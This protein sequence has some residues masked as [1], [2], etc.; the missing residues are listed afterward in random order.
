MSRPV[1]TLL[2]STLYPSAARPLHGIFVET[3]L[4]ELLKTGAVDSRVVAPVPWFPS[5]HERH[6]ERARMARTPSAESRHGI[7]VS[8]PRYLLLPKVGMTLAPWALARAGVAAARRLLAEGFDFDVIDAH[9]FYPDGVAAAMMARQ[10]RKPLV[11]TARGSDIN[12]IGTLAIPRRLMLRAAQSAD[13]CVGVSRALVESMQHMGMA[14][15]K[16][17]VMRNGIDLK[18]FITHPQAAAQDAIGHH[19]QPLL[20]SVGN[21]VPGKGHAL[22]IDALK[23]LL[24][25]RPEAQLVIVGAGPERDRLL[26]HAQAV[27]V[28]HRVHL[29]GQVPNEQLAFWYSAADCLL[30]ASSREGWPNVLLESMACGTPVVATAVG[31]VPEVIS[32]P[33][34]GVLVQQRSAMGLAEAVQKLLRQAPDRLAV[35][36]HAEGFGWAETSAQQLA[37]F[38][39]LACAAAPAGAVHA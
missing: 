6:G 18:R 14:A 20:L 25:T 22:C 29:A 19:G 3:R 10:L 34:A 35:R 16:T 36:R 15:E 8:H 28:Q 2:F 5:T 30:L 17:R 12:L 32:T 37:L 38:R 26:A 1:R 4:R 9:Y 13:A 24:D 11:I 27:G 21:L 39:S 23:L 7:E 31:G 33:A